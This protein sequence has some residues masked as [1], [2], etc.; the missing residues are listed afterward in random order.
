MLLQKAC[1]QAPSPEGLAL[2]AQLLRSLPLLFLAGGHFNLMAGHSLTSQ[3]PGVI[4]FLPAIFSSLFQLTTCVII[5]GNSTKL[6]SL[7]PQHSSPA[8]SGTVI[9]LVQIPWHFLASKDSNYTFIVR[10]EQREGPASQVHLFPC[11]SFSYKGNQFGLSFYV[12]PPAVSSSRN[13][14]KI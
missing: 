10:K 11:R 14:R 4:L 5:N 12:K 9:S 7:L 1:K 2:N 6:W 8:G 3:F 13:I